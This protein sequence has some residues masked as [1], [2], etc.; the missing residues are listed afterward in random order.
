MVWD[1]YRDVLRDFG[2]EA[3]GEA[4][5]GERGE[6]E[7]ETLVIKHQI[8]CRG[9]KTRGG[10]G[11]TVPIYATYE[12]CGSVYRLHTGGGGRQI[13]EICNPNPNPKP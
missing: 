10:S 3:E 7:A 9:G 6:A 4:R 12:I 1:L 13:R 5:R 8:A 11:P 2:C